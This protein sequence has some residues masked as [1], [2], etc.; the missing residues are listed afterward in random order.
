[1]LI[2]RHGNVPRIEGVPFSTSTP[3]LVRLEPRALSA[4]APLFASL[5]A[6]Q[7]NV[8]AVLAG[9][10]PGAA[11][12][13]CAEQPRCALLV[14]ADARYLGGTPDRSFAEQVNALLPR[15]DYFVLFLDENAW[16]PLLGRLLRK[17]FA[18][19]STRLVYQWTGPA[20]SSAPPV[21]Y[22]LRPIDLDLLTSDLENAGSLRDTILCEW[23]SLESF[24]EH[25]FGACAVT[26]TEI[27]SWA[28]ADYVAGADVE[29]GI[30]TQW[31]HRRR[32]L[33]EAVAAL[34]VAQARDRGMT[35]L[36]WHCWQNNAGSRR[37]AVKTGF[38]ERFSYPVYINHWA[39]ENLSDMSPEQFAAFARGYERRLA[40]E[41]PESGFPHVVAAKAWML[42]GE[43]SRAFRCLSV[44]IDMGW[45]TSLDRL[46]EIW[47]EI[48]FVSHLEELP[49]WGEVCSRLGEPLPSHVTPCLSIAEEMPIPD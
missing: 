8:Q 2:S 36:Y 12:V 27:A 18:I 43:P 31:L 33:G 48:E 41:S 5:G 37:I 16:R 1:M 4:V 9:D 6:T 23:V 39:A 10:A 7:L 22:A 49:E 13:D 17:R 38:A 19:R 15:D 20:V 30:E 46:L 3:T 42:A 24:L 14:S 29:L 21:G 40:S 26:D 32:G 34:A 35:G 45:L 28:F 25:G 47:P 44:A 11:F